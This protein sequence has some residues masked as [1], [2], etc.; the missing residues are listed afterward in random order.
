MYA[1]TARGTTTAGQEV[2][3]RRAAAASGVQIR[4][5]YRDSGVSGLRDDRPALARL[6]RDI[7]RDPVIAVLVSTRDRLDRSMRLAREIEK[8]IRET[9][10]LVIEADRDQIE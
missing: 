5:I 7:K 10:A 6:L 3:C 2:R 4:A 1:R 8:Q 9:G